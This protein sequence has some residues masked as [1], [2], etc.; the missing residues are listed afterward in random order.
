MSKDD[1]PTLPFKSVDAWEKWL[2]K[3]LLIPKAFG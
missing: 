1:L 3:H 2:A